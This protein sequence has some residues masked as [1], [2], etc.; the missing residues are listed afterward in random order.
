MMLGG[1]GLTIFAGMKYYRENNMQNAEVPNLVPN[2]EQNNAQNKMS[3]STI[4][5]DMIP[6]KID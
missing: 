3:I 5:A 6:P 4:Q 1:L 2:T